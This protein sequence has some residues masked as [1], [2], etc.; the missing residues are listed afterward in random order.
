MTR[1]EFSRY[2]RGSE[3]QN[4]GAKVAAWAKKFWKSR[5]G[6]QTVEIMKSISK[7][8]NEKKDEQTY[9]PKATLKPKTDA[10]TSATES[11]VN[12]AERMF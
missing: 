2:L 11:L 3:V 7:Y 9:F 12:E 1:D 6:K 5:Y 4:D 8:E 10:V